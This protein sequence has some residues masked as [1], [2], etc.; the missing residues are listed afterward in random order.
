[1]PAV[2]DNDVY[3]VDYSN[4]RNSDGSY[5]FNYELSD[6]QSRT[7]KGALK[8]VKDADGNDV[9]IISVTGQYS[10]VAPNGQ[11]YVT[12]YISDEK[13]YRV[14]K[15]MNAEAIGRS[16]DTTFDAVDVKSDDDLAIVTTTESEIELDS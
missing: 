12:F 6:G 4:E 13:G 16:L 8:D 7:E 5:S 15:M 9:K 3:L 11:K 1:M 14:E 10:F 2:K